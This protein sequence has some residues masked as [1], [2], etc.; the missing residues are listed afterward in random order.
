M[1]L[2][3]LFAIL[4]AVM[5][6]GSFLPAVFA[7]S[8]SDDTIQTNT[9]INVTAREDLIKERVQVRTEFKDSNGQNRDQFKT[10]QDKSKAEREA[11]RDDFKGSRNDTNLS[12]EDSKDL[13]DQF[14]DEREKIREEQKQNFEDFKQRREQVREE[15]KG[16][17]E[18]LREQVKQSIEDAKNLRDQ[19]KEERKNLEG[20]R[21]DFKKECAKD[22]STGNSSE[23]C[24]RAKEDLQQGRKDVL[25]NAAEQVLKA[26]SVT[27]TRVETNP[28][29]DNATAASI[30]AELSKRQV[31]VTDAQAKVTALTNQST[32]NETKAAAEALKTATQEA[33]VTLKL[34]H[35]ALVN[36]DFQKFLNHFTTMSEKFKEQSTKLHAAGKDTTKL[37]AAI[38]SFDAKIASVTTSFNQAKASFVTA[39]QTAKTE[40]DAEAILKAEREQLEAA[41]KDAQGARD[42][43]K[44][45]V[46]ELRA[47]DANAVSEVAKAMSAESAATDST[48][49]DTGVNA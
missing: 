4:L 41:R 46:K 33:R 23:T 17:I 19:F 25:G 40:A 37:D 27:K 16:K 10:E 36:A 11:A 13:R 29:L 21:D 2:Q 20:K 26:L 43:L 12:K 7:E 24:K 31:S 45:I 15:F 5:V 3:Q 1:K 39:M 35:G 47:L 30:L 6:V 18:Q 48:D 14:K 49:V 44:N 22:N 8:G 42:D 9:S 38:V 34:A 32:V 28:N